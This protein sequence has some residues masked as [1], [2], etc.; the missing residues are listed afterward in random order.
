MLR[1]WPSWTV[2]RKF[3]AEEEVGV[4]RLEGVL[5]GLEVDAVQD[6]VEVAAVGLDLRMRLALQRGLDRQLVEAEDVA[7]HGARPPR[8]AP[9]R[10]PTPR[11]PLSARQP[12]RVEAVD[13]LGATA[14]V[15]EVANQ[16]PTLTLSA[17]CA[18]ASRATGTRYGEQLT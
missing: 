7:Q 16:S 5:G 13:Q 1:R 9:R 18:A 15:D 17:A 11:T 14:P 6:D 2:T 3:G 4:V 8:S 10:P 12:R